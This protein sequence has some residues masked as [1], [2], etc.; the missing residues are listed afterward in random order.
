MKKVVYI[1]VFGLLLLHIR[2]SAQKKPN[3][4]FIYTDDL[5]YGDISCYGATKIYTPNIDKLAQSGLR[6]T[7]AH[8]SSAT[9]TPSGIRSSRVYMPGVKRHGHSQGECGAFD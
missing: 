1:I 3:I 7:N 6:F 9:C 8:S 2:L 5:G 4:V